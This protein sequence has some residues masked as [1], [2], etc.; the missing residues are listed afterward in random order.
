MYLPGKDCVIMN[1]DFKFKKPTFQNDNLVYVCKVT[2][3]IKSLN[4]VLLSL[5][6][7]RKKEIIVEGNAQCKILSNY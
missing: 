1:V 2:K 3:I 4:V 6:I 7:L 5:H